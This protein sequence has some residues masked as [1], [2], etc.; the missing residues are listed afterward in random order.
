MWM[1][2]GKS[3][4][5]KICESSKRC[6]DR[7][8]GQEQKVRASL[9]F[10]NGKAPWAGDGSIGSGNYWYRRLQGLLMLTVMHKSSGYD[11]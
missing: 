4:V 9:L 1:A 5:V 2:L 3:G 10:G 11:L 8:F 7:M 6:S